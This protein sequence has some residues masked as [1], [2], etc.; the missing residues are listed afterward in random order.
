[1]TANPLLSFLRRKK[2]SAEEESVAIARLESQLAV[3]GW[4]IG[5]ACGVLRGVYGPKGEHDLGILLWAVSGLLLVAIA[6]GLGCGLGY[7]L[8]RLVRR[9]RSEEQ[10]E[11]FTSRTSQPKE[12]QMQSLGGNGGHQE[13]ELVSSLGLGSAVGSFLGAVT[14]LVAGAW[15]NALYGAAIGAFLV[16]LAITPY[17]DLVR[18]VLHMMVRD[19]QNKQ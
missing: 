16:S 3:C 17:G 11:V 18:I 4:C 1:M 15:A 5:C 13:A 9:P 7:G 19:R 8:A 12:S 10:E 2:T 6:S 14:M